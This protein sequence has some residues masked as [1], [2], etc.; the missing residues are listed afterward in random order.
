ERMA[1]SW[2]TAPTLLGEDEKPR[3]QRCP[4]NTL[5]LQ[6][7]APDALGRLLVFGLFSSSRESLWSTSSPSFWL[8]LWWWG[9]G[10]PPR[11]ARPRPVCPATTRRCP[12][13]PPSRRGRSPRL[14]R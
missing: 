4:K 8:L 2:V 7:S 13:P 1:V 9:S 3:Q 10:S 6:V 14:P 11:L 5:T 12:W